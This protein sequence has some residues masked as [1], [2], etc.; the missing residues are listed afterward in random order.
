MTPSHSTPVSP[1]SDDA[2][3]AEAAQWQVRRHD[4][5]TA[6]EEAQF[7]AW[8]ALGA[9]RQ[10]AYARFDKV[11]NGLGELPSQAVARLTAS[12]PPASMRQ[13]PSA[14]EHKPRRWLTGWA[15]VARP[16]ATAALAITVAGGGWLGW[17]HWQ[18]QPVYTET[19]ATV[20]GQQLNVELPD[21]SML[22]LDTGTR[23]QVTL[24]RDRREVRLPEGQALFTVKA[25]AARPF[26]VFTDRMLV[27]VVGTRFSVRNTRTGLAQNVGVQVEEGRVR[28][29]MLD[30][31]KPAGAPVLLTAGQQVQSDAAGRLAPMAPGGAMPWREGRVNFDRTPLGQAV[32]EF[33]RY[34][35][36]GLVIKDPAVAALRVNGSFDLRQADAFSQ[37]LPLVLP[38][39]LRARGGET[40]IIAKTSK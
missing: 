14:R 5:L 36:T 21:G 7:Q 22:G 32:A 24:Y 18:A 16:M 40:E 11:W 25:D 39:Q 37:T 2:L 30:Q 12:L 28:V 38:V 29:S 15:G 23:A 27:T 3:Y 10:A 4:G 26:H 34:G 6:E 35:A 9:G 13:T 20:R 8:L 17:N 1:L 33:E 31:G 19:F